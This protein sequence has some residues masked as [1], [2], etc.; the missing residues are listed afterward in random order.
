MRISSEARQKIQL[1]LA[2]AILIAAVRSGYIL[3]DR[4]V[5]K[6]EEAKKRSTALNPDYYVVRKK[7]YLY[8]L[9]SARQSTR[10]PVCVIEGYGSTY[11][12]YATVRRRTAC[13]HASG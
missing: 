4:H 5:N 3:Y 2:A 1:V 8:D 10:Q 13:A 11:Y 6:I 7:L 9:T 12:P